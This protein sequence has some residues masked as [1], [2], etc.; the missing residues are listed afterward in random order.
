ML[1]IHWRNVLGFFFL[2]LNINIHILCCLSCHMWMTHNRWTSS[3]MTC[4]FMLRL[5]PLN[6]TTVTVH[7]PVL[8]CTL[9]MWLS[10]VWPEFIQAE[11]ER[12]H[13]AHHPT[14]SLLQVRGKLLPCGSY[15]RHQER[16]SSI[17]LCCPHSRTSSVHLHTHSLT[18]H[19]WRELCLWE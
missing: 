12:Y 7:E 9:S 8:F 5:L 11:N 14:G 4:I 19:C 10:V 13:R 2:V 18:V 1:W 16:M 17:I 3:C 6:H 15:D